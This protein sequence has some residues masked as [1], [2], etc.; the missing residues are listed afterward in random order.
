MW[1]SKEKAFV[2]LWVLFPNRAKTILIRNYWS[3]IAQWAVFCVNNPWPIK[4]AVRYRL[5]SDTKHF[6]SNHIVNGRTKLN[7]ALQERCSV[8]IRSQKQV[9]STE[10]IA[11]TIQ[12]SRQIWLTFYYVRLKKFLFS[13]VIFEQA[14]SIRVKNIVIDYH[15]FDPYR[16]F[17][18]HDMDQDQWFKI[19]QIRVHPRNRSIHSV[20]KDS[21]VPLMRHDSS[22]LGS[23]ILCRI[24]KER[25]QACLSALNSCS[26]HLPD[27]PQTKMWK[28]Q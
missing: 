25:T 16:A 24:S 13:Q 15:L 11:M 18:W 28:H 14:L 19:I 12:F 6:M 17:L 2:S 7:F 5:K 22:D 20:F 4:Q 27:P 3:N 10:V 26:T 1:W 23:L 21:P 8:W 9:Q